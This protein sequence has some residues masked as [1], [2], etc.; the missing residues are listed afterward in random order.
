MPTEPVV[1]EP[2]FQYKI[3]QDNRIC[4]MNK[5]GKNILNYYFS[6]RLRVFVANLF[7]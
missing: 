5:K 6:L 3:R 2:V 1:A 7:G 4:W